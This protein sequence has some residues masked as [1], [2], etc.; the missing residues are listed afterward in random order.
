MTS[1]CLA[2]R[3]ELI[4][5]TL[6]NGRFGSGADALRGA[7]WRWSNEGGTGCTHLLVTLQCACWGGVGCTSE[8]Y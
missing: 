1:D 3:L 8:A 4:S 2:P 5:L 7:A 6:L